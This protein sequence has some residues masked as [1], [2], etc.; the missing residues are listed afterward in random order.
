MAGGSLNHM[1]QGDDGRS[2]GKSLCGL[3]E[4]PEGNLSSGEIGTRKSVN[5]ARCIDIATAQGIIAPGQ[6]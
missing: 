1:Y 4:S 5:C 2:R 6:N 3:A